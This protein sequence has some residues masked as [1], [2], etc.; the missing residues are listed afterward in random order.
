L[1]GRR[2]P[3]TP[4]K[5]HPRSKDAQIQNDVRRHR[6]SSLLKS[7]AL[8]LSSSARQQLRDPAPATKRDAGPRRVWQ[9]ISQLGN[10]P[11]GAPAAPGAFL[12]PVPSPI[13]LVRIRQLLRLK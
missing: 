11:K 13:G 2:L 3:P 12:R 7:A 8:R 4:A 1:G 6:S 9:E 5:L 10:S